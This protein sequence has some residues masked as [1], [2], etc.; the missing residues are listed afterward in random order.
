MRSG[1]LH[2]AAIAVIEKDEVLDAIRQSPETESSSERNS[3][4]L[5]S[6]SST[7]A[8]MTMGQEARAS[9]E[10]AMTRFACARASASR[11]RRPFSASLASCA[12]TDS[13]ASRAAPG[14]LSWSSAR[15]PACAAIWAMPRPMTPVPTTARLKSGRE[16]SR[17]MMQ[18][19]K[20]GI[21]RVSPAPRRRVDVPGRFGQAC[22]IRL[23]EEEPHA[24]A[25][26]HACAARVAGPG[27]AGS[28]PRIP[29]ASDHAHLPLAARRIDRYPSAA[30]RRNRGEIPG[31]AGLD[32]EPA[33]RRR[34][35]GAG[36]LG[37]DGQ[38]RRLCAFAD[39]HGRVPHP[40][41][42]EA[43]LGYGARLHLY[44]R[45][46]G[47]YL[48]RGGE[49]RFAVQILSRPPRLCEGP[50]GTDVLRVYRDRH[51]SASADGGSVDE[52][53]RPIPPC[54]VQ[55]QC[56]FHAGAPRRPHHGAVGFERLGAL[57]RR[58]A[59]QVAG[60]VWENADQALAERAHGERSGT[61]HGLQFSLR[62]RR[63]AR[64][65]AA[66]RE[67]PA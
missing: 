39:A 11:S 50:S 67:D 24:F 47:L 65:G 59:V 29:L 38:A 9:R 12:E 5:A 21:L 13:F 45:P 23:L 57:R 26:T 10:S 31:P 63:P 7:I 43:C 32:R 19:G 15:I 2:A 51:L 3:A 64:N 58:G 30:L 54:A 44:H 17:G 66:G 48:R 6:R 35:G 22:A 27:A 18:S 42:A 37:A 8:S 40:A 36:S 33:R 14:R 4:R 53:R 56:G 1:P 28:G 55:G 34:D 61:R 25:R 60:D 62:H 46:V 49:E 52:N 16:T 41:Y 20:A